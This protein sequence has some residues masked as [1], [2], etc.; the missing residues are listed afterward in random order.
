MREP[1]GDERE[2]IH[3]PECEGNF[4]PNSEQPFTLREFLYPSEYENYKKTGHYPSQ[5]NR[6]IFCIRCELARALIYIRANGVS[7]KQDSI[8][9]KHRNLVNIKGEYRL[10]DCILTKKDCWEG[11]IDPVVLHTRNSYRWKLINGTKTYEQ[12]RIMKPIHFLT[13]KPVRN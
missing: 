9:Q 4:I 13:E 7:C 2:C 1:V 5:Q 6:C 11:I 8:L 10:E 3:G 12:W